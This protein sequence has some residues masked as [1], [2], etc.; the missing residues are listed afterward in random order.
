[1]GTWV[2]IISTGLS[3]PVAREVAG[4]AVKQEWP[5]VAGVL[6]RCRPSRYDCA[7]FHDRQNPN[8]D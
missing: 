2:W 1:M 6:L 3:R 5:G 7:R 8:F 4:Q